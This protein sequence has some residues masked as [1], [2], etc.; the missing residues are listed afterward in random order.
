MLGREGN[1]DLFNTRVIALY[2]EGITRGRA[3]L[4]AARAITPH[5]TI[6]AFYVGESKAG[7]AAVF[8]HT[9]A[10]AGPDELYE[11]MFRQAGVIRARSVLE[12][13]EACC[14]LGSM[15]VPHGNRV[16]I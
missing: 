11:G 1:T 8:S 14:L 10:M 16:V 5:K 6:V 12:L 15:P 9:G 2:I 13:F 4:E 3:F 7:K